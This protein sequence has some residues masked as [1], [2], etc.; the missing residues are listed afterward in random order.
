MCNDC[1]C[2]TVQAT[3]NTSKNC[4]HSDS[5]KNSIISDLS[6]NVSTYTSVA[7]WNNT[8]IS[9]VI[10]RFDSHTEKS[11][12]DTMK[13][14]AINID[15]TKFIPKLGSYQFVVIDSNANDVITM[16]AYRL[17]TTVAPLYEQFFP[18][19]KSD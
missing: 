2:C 17:K 12:I 11:S 15:E 8:S 13:I 9:T 3:P 14:T 18:N 19:V 1:K 16:T 10:R 4:Q 6:S 5:F 7:K